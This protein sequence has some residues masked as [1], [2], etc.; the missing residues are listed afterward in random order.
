MSFVFK[1]SLASFPLFFVF[2]AR[3]PGHPAADQL[4]KLSILTGHDM[5]PHAKARFGPKARIGCS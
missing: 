5:H 4:D 3:F 1:Y 2:R